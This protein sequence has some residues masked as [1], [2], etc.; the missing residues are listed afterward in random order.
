MGALSVPIPSRRLECF[1]RPAILAGS[2]AVLL[3]VFW[4]ASRY[5]QPD[6]Q[7]PTRRPG[8]AEHDL[9]P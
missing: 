9:Q 3:C 7:G 2:A 1:Y 8:D 5:P 4:F 6:E